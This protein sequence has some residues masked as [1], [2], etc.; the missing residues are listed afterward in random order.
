MAIGQKTAHSRQKSFID[1]TETPSDTSPPSPPAADDGLGLFDEEFYEEIVQADLNREAKVLQQLSEEPPD[2]TPDSALNEY[3]QTKQKIAHKIAHDVLLSVSTGSV[4]TET[5]SYLKT[6]EAS[7]NE[8]NAVDEQYFSEALTFDSTQNISHNSSPSHYNL[9]QSASAT[10]N[11]SVHNDFGVIDE[12]YFSTLPRTGTNILKDVPATHSDPEAEPR[13]QS[14]HLSQLNSDELNYFDQI[15]TGTDLPVVEDNP[16]ERL[17]TEA[18]RSEKSPNVGSANNSQVE[19]QP[20]LRK[21]R[22]SPRI[23]SDTAGIDH[24]NSSIGN[25]PEIAGTSVSEGTYGVP[26]QHSS[27]ESQTVDESIQKTRKIS[28]KLRLD[29]RKS[30]PSQLGEYAT[31]EEGSPS[32]NQYVILH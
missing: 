32:D 8:L 23:S 7:S 22:Q 6:P 10:N 9:K 15:M 13:T 30:Q 25:G 26:D 18:V 11:D 16:A 31:E 19:N 24:S 5:L 2:V 27:F 21:R 29:P 14:D 4:Q 17:R 12:H 28:N 3:T 1:S 20:T